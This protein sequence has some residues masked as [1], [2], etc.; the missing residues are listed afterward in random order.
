MNH[1]ESNP[2]LDLRYPIVFDRI[3]TAHVEPAI[4]ELIRRCEQRIEGLASLQGQRT[5]ENTLAAIDALT[6]DLDTAYG[7]T[8]HLEMTVSSPELRAAYNAVEPKASAFYARIALHEGLWRALQEFAA[9]PEAASLTGAS[10]RLLT[11][12][13]DGFRRRGAGL[14]PEKKAELERIEVELARETTK[15][16]ENVLD[17]TKQFELIIEDEKQLAGLP[18]TAIEIARESAAACQ[19]PGWRFTL[20]APSYLAVMTYLDDRSI[21]EHVYRAYQSR[22]STGPHSNGA[23]IVRI[24]ELRRLKARLLGYHDFAD[25][26][27]E[28]RMAGSGAKAQ[29]FL[30]E[31]RARTSP[32]F[33]RENQE[34]TEFRRHLEGPDA[35]PLEAWDVA[36][37][38]EKVRRAKYDYDAEKLRPYFSLEHVLAGLFQLVERLF[39]VLVREKPGVPGWDPAVKFYELVDS[40]GALLGAFYADW[41]PRENKRQGAWMDV[42][43]T[44]G[45]RPGQPFEPHLG[46]MCGNLTPPSGGKPS[47]LTHREV[48]TIFHEFGHLL[49]HCLS[50]V[51]QRSLAGVNVPSDFVELPSQIME[52]WC[53]ERE[54]LDLFAR[55]WETGEPVPDELFQ[56]LRRVKAFRAAN[57]Q[58]R[59]LGFGFTDLALHR[60]YDPQ[61]DA[62]VIAYSKRILQQ[63]SPA[64]LPAD[65]A[66]LNSFSHLFS[67]SSAYAAGYYSYKWSEVLDADAFTRFQKEGI[68]SRE[69]GMSFRHNILERGNSEEVGTLYRN[70]LG[71]EPDPAALLRRAGLIGE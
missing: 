18:P 48:E 60:L 6:T 66:M 63:F 19:K 8:R 64:P 65:H 20:Q 42:L 36:Y 49:H 40:G 62:D 71:R 69:A 11:K 27:T 45:P 16:N 10:K 15:F 41:F 29:A 47:L 58:M 56:Q 13:L 46:L 4:D 14:P 2:L 9:T 67:D 38:H 59:Q 30:E 17:S 22:A 39:G 23:R 26:I 37:Y 57:E 31:L 61:R 32:F 55:H 54:S 51:E 5:Y 34:L 43:L 12:T 1:S 50:Q 68:F 25:F 3:R 52:N 53:W 24:L 70:F 33:A 35:P 7:V 28:D 44:G 21:R